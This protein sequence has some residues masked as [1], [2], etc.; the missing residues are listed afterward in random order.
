MIRIRGHAAIYGEVWYDEEPPYTSGVDIVLYRHRPVPLAGAGSVPFLSLVTD[1]APVAEDIAQGFDKDCRYE[2]RRAETKDGLRT[3]YIADPR[4]RL[5]D[6]IQFYD[7]F[8][9]QKSL[10]PCYREWLGAACEAGQLILTAAVS[11]DA[12]LVWHA[13]IRCG[14]TAGLEYSGSLFRKRESDYRA[15]V[16][17]AN[18]WLHW[19]DML[20]LK[21]AGLTRYDWGGLFE[22]E[23]MPQRAGINGFKRGFGGRPERSYDCTVPVTMRGRL[24][25]PVRDAWRRWQR[26]GG[27]AAKSA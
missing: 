12:I 6:F 24:Y 20:R 10:P 11:D 21:Q 19:Q 17:R 27:A 7:D 22:D 25:L 23:S 26:P 1:L 18:R 3:E 5:E 14:R 4:P 2:I 9:R 8:A 15:L 13:Y 16:G